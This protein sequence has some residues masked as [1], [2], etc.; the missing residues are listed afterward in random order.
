MRVLLVIYDNDMYIHWF[1]QGM[2]YIAAVLR[3]AGHEVEIYNQDVH[4]Y[5]EEHLTRYLDNNRYDLIGVSVVGGYYQYRKLLSISEAINKS[6]NRPFY[7]IGGHG[8]SPEPEY[9]LHKTQAD[10]VVI[11]EGERTIVQL[12]DALFHKKKLRDVKGIAFRE[13]GEV[14]INER[15]PLIQD[16][17][18]IPFPAYDLFPIDYYRLLRMPYATNSDFVMPILSG[19]GCTFQCNFCYR[20]DQG[21]RP[22]R[23]ESIIEEIELLKKS[24][25][26][27]YIAFGDELLMSSVERTVS[28]CSAFIKAKLNIKW[29]K[30]RSVP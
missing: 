17:D 12:I 8:P 9:F 29:M 14:V 22:R 18:S 2:G 1:P 13:A 21:F 15:Q 28:L 5:P 10:A 24:Y 19:R 7:V 30:K 6:K 16:I 27:T 11:G 26:I 4:H 20:M 23:G 25:G 3:E